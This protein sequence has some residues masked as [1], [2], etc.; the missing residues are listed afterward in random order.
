MKDIF[1]DAQTHLTEVFK[2]VELSD[3]I[4]K[5][6]AHPK[7]SITVSIPLRMD[8]GSL[9]V[10]TGYRVQFDDTRGPTKGGVRFHPDVSLDEISTLSFWMTIKC[11]V[12]GLPFGGAKGGISVNAKELSSLELEGYRVGIFVPLPT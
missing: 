12:A 9:R 6:L 1:S 10:F 8:D 7:L 11:A 2:Y 5:R 4:R 3:D